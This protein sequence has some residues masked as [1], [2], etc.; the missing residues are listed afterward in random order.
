LYVQFVLEMQKHIDE[1]TMK[2]AV[3]TAIQVHYTSIWERDTVKYI[4]CD[5]A[6]SQDQP[7]IL[8]DHKMEWL[9][10]VEYLGILYVNGLVPEVVLRSVLDRFA[11][12]RG[13]PDENLVEGM[14]ALLL[15]DGVVYKL[16]ST[17]KGEGFITAWKGL[18]QL[19][20]LGKK[21][22]KYLELKSLFE[23]VTSLVENK[24]KAPRKTAASKTHNSPELSFQDSGGRGGKPRA[25]RTPVADESGGRFEALRQGLGDDSPD[26]RGKGYKGGKGDKGGGKGD[27][28]MPDPRQVFVAGIGSGAEDE[29]KAFFGQV[30]DVDRVKV[31]RTPEGDSRDVCFITFRSEDQA[32]QAL[33]LHGSS[34]AGRNLTVR[35]ANGKKGAEKG[36]SKGGGPSSPSSGFFDRLPPSDTAPDLGGA[37]RFDVLAS[38]VSERLPDDLAGLGLPPPRSSNKGGKGGSKGAKGKGEWMTEL[39]AALEEELAAQD[40]GPVRLTDF[41]FTAKRFLSELKTKDRVDG[42]TR[43]HGAVSFVLEYTAGKERSAVKK[44]TAYTFTLLQKFDP[45]FADDFKRRDEERRR[46]ADFK[47]PGQEDESL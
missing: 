41:D 28:D 33:S 22:T 32:Q 45:E 8:E 38:P 3:L 12:L 20:D 17:K 39:D 5:D 15:T 16:F 24:G 19:A 36:A 40:D 4:G 13:S 43:F 44:W 46:Q 37:S 23:Q 35:I 27:A 30:G 34:F 21:K 25:E 31:L 42:T 10:F 11:E 9:A 29:I 2:K 7:M 47:R 18:K 1:K 14:C 26:R 6:E